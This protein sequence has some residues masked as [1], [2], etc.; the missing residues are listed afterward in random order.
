MKI[1]FRTAIFF[2]AILL[3]ME[4]PREIWAA[5][6]SSPEYRRPFELPQCPVGCVIVLYGPLPKGTFGKVEEKDDW[7][8][9]LSSVGVK[10]PKGGFALFDRPARVLAVATDAKNQ[11]LMKIMAE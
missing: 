9:Y 7:K 8:E 5:W 6:S 4:G 2:F 3:A 1:N 10:F 11:D